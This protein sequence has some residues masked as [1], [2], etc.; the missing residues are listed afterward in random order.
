MGLTEHLFRR[1][2]GGGLRL[3]RVIRR[4]RLE[5]PMHSKPAVR[6]VAACMQSMIAMITTT[7]AARAAF[8]ASIHSQIKA[9]PDPHKRFV[10]GLLGK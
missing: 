2:L 8:D 9:L 5:R 3:I 6:A 7:T 10:E 4:Q 1:A